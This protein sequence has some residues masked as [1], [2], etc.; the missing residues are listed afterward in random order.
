[1]KMGIYIRLSSPTRISPI[2]WALSRLDYCYR[3]IRYFQQ[4]EVFLP[5]TVKVWINATTETLGGN[6]KREIPITNLYNDVKILLSWIK[7]AFYREELFS[8]IIVFEGTWQFNHVKFA[9]FFSVN[10][11]YAWRQAYHDV[12]IDAYGKGEYED[13][14][15]YLWKEH[16]IDTITPKFL[17]EVKREGRGK[18]AKPRE[19]YFSIGAPEY[20][21]IVNLVALHLRDWRAF[22]DFLYSRLRK[23]K[24]SWI[25]N[26]VAPIDRS[27]FLSSIKAQKVV[28]SVLKRLLEESLLVEQGG[29]SVTYIARGRESF[30]NFYKRFKEEVFKSATKELPEADTLKKKIKKGLEG[31]ETL[32]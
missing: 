25:K 24:A 30:I 29:N 6:L 28:Q 4:G 32:V 19:I 9:G 31:I 27:F 10:N 16:L 21:E 3:T 26:K 8:S 7:D 22:V 13:L 12:E 23:D 17:D 18:P 2:E 1:M 20:G 15:D 5:T 14:V 11:E